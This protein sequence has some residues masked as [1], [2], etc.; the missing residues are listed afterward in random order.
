M[1]KPRVFISSTFYDLKHIRSSLENFIDT[2]GYESILSEK[3]SIAYNPDI[4][5][6]ESCYREV[7]SCD[8]FVLIIGGRYGS[9][10]SS[11]V[12]SDQKDFFTRYESITKL[13]YENAIKSDT[14]IYILIERSVYSEYDTFKKNRNNKTI[15]YA[16][17]DS[18]NIFDF[19]DEIL[20]QPKNN[21]IYQFERHID[22]ESWLRLQW[23]GLFQELIRK[24]KS[25]TDIAE[26][27]K[28]VKELSNINTTLK[29]YLEEIV[30]TTDKVNGSEIIEEE[31]ERLTKS[32]M[33][34]NFS[35]LKVVESLIRLHNLKVEEVVNMI[36]N[37]ND[38]K[39]LAATFAEILK[40]N[41]NGKRLL[42]YWTEAEAVRKNFNEAREILGLP[43]LKI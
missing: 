14:P 15:K 43:D 1:A 9:S 25:Q 11:E 6:D 7:Q 24:R 23:A 38:F 26:L 4:P 28:E 13:E 36:S 21:P 34:N 32:R 39:D 30:S 17:V 35:K 2:L 31:E 29:R 22:I 3:G 12:K 37:A 40:E 20:S 27:S 33:F 42:Q 10:A 16:H 5:L 41:D 8:I 19:I 18:V